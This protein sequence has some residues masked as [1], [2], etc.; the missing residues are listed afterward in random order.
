MESSEELSSG[1]FLGKILHK[2]VENSLRKGRCNNNSKCLTGYKDLFVSAI[3]SSELGINADPSYFTSLAFV[4]KLIIREQDVAAKKGY[5]LC[6][7]LTS[8]NLDLENEEPV[9]DENQKSERVL[10]VPQVVVISLRSIFDLI[11]E[12]QVTHP[13]LCFKVLKALL[14]ILQNLFPESL[15]SEPCHVVEPLFEL[16][17]KLSTM[18]DAENTSTIETQEVGESLSSLASSCLLSLVI[19]WGVTPRILQALDALITVARPLA[20]QIIVLPNIMLTLQKGVRSTVIGTSHVP[21]WFTQG[22]QQKTLVTCFSVNL[23]KDLIENSI[24]CDGPFIF[25]L[26]SCGLYKIGSGL[27]STVS[28]RLYASNKKNVPKKGT[29]L[30]FNGQLFLHTYSKEDRNLHIVDN[31]TLALKDCINL[32]DSIGKNS[33]LFSDGNRLGSVFKTDE[34]ELHATLFEINK[35]ELFS[36]GES[37]LRLALQSLYIVGASI[38][39]EN[40]DLRQIN[41]N[42]DEGFTSIVAGKEFMLMVSSSGKVSYQGKASSLGLKTVGELVHNQEQT[43]NRW[44]ELPLPKSPSIVRC[45]TGHDGLH[46]V[47]LG[48][49]GTA[50]FAGLAKRGEDGDLTKHRRQQ[51]SSRPKRFSSIEGKVVVD[52]ACNNGSSAMVTKD[53]EL[54]LFGKDSTYCESTSGRLLGIKDRIV[55]VALG[56]AHGVTLTDKGVVY[57]FGINNKGQCGRDLFSS[58]QAKQ[59]ENNS[60]LQ[61]TTLLSACKEPIDDEIESEDSGS[62]TEMK[63]CAAD[64][65]H[66]SVD[67]CM[68][69]TQCGQCTGFGSTC[70]NTNSPGRIPGT[71]CGCGSGEAGCTVCGACR[72]CARIPN[73]DVG[74]GLPPAPVPIISLGR[75]RGS[76]MAANNAVLMGRFVR[77]PAEVFP[78]AALVDVANFRASRLDGRGIDDPK[79]REV[80]LGAALNADVALDGNRRHR[81]HRR[82][83][84]SEVKVAMMN[85]EAPKGWDAK[86][87]PAGQP[88]KNGIDAALGS[89]GDRDTNKLASLSPGPIS[90]HSKVRVSQVACGLHHSVLLTTDGQVY[91]FGSNSYGQLGV[92]DLSS[93]GSP[94]LVKMPCAVNISMIAAGSHHTVVLTTDGDVLTWGAH[95]KGQLARDPSNID[96]CGA[97]SIVWHSVP[98]FVTHIGPKCGKRASWIGASGDQ[99]FFKLEE[100]LVSEEEFHHSTVLATD[101]YFAILPTHSKPSSRNLVI[102]RNDGQCRSFSG[103][104]QANFANTILTWDPVYSILWSFCKS[105]SMVRGYNVFASGLVH[106]SYGSSLLS[107]MKEQESVD[108]AD[109]FRP[110]LTLP[111]VPSSKVTQTQAALHLLCCLDSLTRCQQIPIKEITN[112]DPHKSLV[113][114]CFTKEDFSV[115]NR[116]ESHGGGWGYSGHSVEAIRFM[117]DTD[118]LLGGFSL[119]GGRGEYMGKIKVFDLGIGGGDQEG[120]GE[121]LAETDEVVYECGAR[122]RF[123]ILFSQPLRL[124][125]NRWYLAWARVNGPSSDCGSGGQSTVTTEDQVTFTFKPSKKSNNG[126]DVNAGQLPQILFRV[127]AHDAPSSKPHSSIET[128]HSISSNFSKVVTPDSFTALLNLTQWAW[129]ALKAMTTNGLTGPEVNLKE[130]HAHIQDLSRIV[131]VCRVSMRLLRFYILELYPVKS[132][133]PKKLIEESVAVVRAIVNVRTTLRSILSDPVLGLLNK[134]HTVGLPCNSTYMVMLEQVAKETHD[135]FVACFHVFYPTASLKWTILCELLD[136]IQK[137]SNAPGNSDQLLAAVIDSLCSHHIRLRSAVPNLCDLQE[138]LHVRRQFQSPEMEGAPCLSSP[139]ENGSTSPTLPQ[140]DSHQFPVLVEHMVEGQS[141]VHRPC[142]A[143]LDRLFLIATWPVRQSLDMEPVI[144]SDKLVQYSCRLLA[145]VVAELASQ[146]C[147]IEELDVSTTRGILATPSRF[148]SSSQNRSWNTGNG[149]PDA[150]CFTVDRPNVSVIGVGVFGG[151]GSYTYELELLELIRSASDAAQTLSWHSLAVVRGSYGPEDSIN[152]VAEIKF[153]RPVPIKENTRYTFRLRN[154]GGKTHNGDGGVLSIKGPD[155]TTFNFSACLLSFNGTNHIRGQLPYILYCNIPSNSEVQQSSLSAIGNQARKSIMSITSSI[156]RCTS[157]LLCAARSLPIHHSLPIIC[158]SHVVSYLL[159]FVVANIGVV[160]ESDPKNAVQILELIRVLLPHVS[161]LCLADILSSEKGGNMPD[162]DPC[163]TTSPKV[164]VVE[165]DHPYRPATV[166]HFRVSFPESVRW[167]CLEFDGQ[168]CTSQVE[169]SLQL[170]LPSVFPKNQADASLADYW[171]ALKKFGG[172]DNWPTHSMIL[173]GNEVIFS[174]ESASDCIR[175]DKAS[176]WGFRCTVVGYEWQE[177]NN[178]I[179]LLETELAYLGGMCSATLMKRDLALPQSRGDEMDADSMESITQQIY[180]A[181]TGLLSKG[182]A[183]SQLPTIHEA[184]EGNLPFSVS[185][186]ERQF[187]RDFVSASEETSGGRLARWLQPESVVDPSKSQLIFPG[188]FSASLATFGVPNS[189]SLGTIGFGSPIKSVTND[190]D[191]EDEETPSE[192]TTVTSTTTTVVSEGLRAGW[193]AILTLLTRDQYGHLVH[194]PNLKVNIR[195]VPCDLTQTTNDALLSPTKRLYSGDEKNC[196]EHLEPVLDVPY[197]VT[198]KD[199]MC[200]HAITFLKAYENYSFEELRFVSPIKRR[201]SETMLVRPNADGSYSANWTPSAAGLYSIHVTIDGYPL[202]EV[203]KVDVKEPPQGVLPPSH[204]VTVRN[205]SSPSHRLRQFRTRASAGLRVRAQPS[206]QGEQI[207]IVACEGTISF[208]EELCNDDGTWLR[209]STESIREWCINPYSEAWCLQYNQHISKTLLFPIST[210]QNEGDEMGDDPPSHHKNSQ[211]DSDKKEEKVFSSAQTF[212]VVDCGASGHNIRALPSLKALPVG[213]LKLGSSFLV[214]EQR[215]TSEGAWVKLLPSS[216]RQ[217]CSNNELEAWSLAVDRHQMVYLRHEDEVLSVSAGSDKSSPAQLLKP[218]YD[219]SESAERQANLSAFSSPEPVSTFI[220]GIDKDSEFPRPTSSQKSPPKGEID[221]S[222]KSNV[223]STSESTASLHVQEASLESSVEDAGALVGSCGP[224]AAVA[225]GRL[226]A[227]QNWLRRDGSLVKE[228]PSPPPRSRNF[229]PELQGVSVKDMVRVMGESRANGN[230]SPSSSPIPSRKTGAI[231]VVNRS[232]SAHSSPGGCS[233][234][235]GSL[236]SSGTVKLE[237]TQ[238][239]RSLSPATQM[240]QSVDQSVITVMAKNVTQMGTQ[241]S[242]EANKTNQ[243]NLGAELISDLTRSPQR[244]SPKASRTKERASRGGTRSRKSR[245][246]TAGQH[247]GGRSLMLEQEIA[248]VGMSPSTAECLRAVF[249]AN[250]WH[251]GLVH[252]AMACAS[253]LK[254][255]PNLPKQVDPIVPLRGDPRHRKTREE[256]ARQRHSVEIFSTNMLSGPFA[257]P[258]PVALEESW[259]TERGE[260]ASNHQIQPDVPDNKVASSLTPTLS[261]LVELWEKMSG[262]CV[263]LIQSEPT[264]SSSTLSV[265]QFQNESVSK[266]KPK[267]ENRDARDKERKRKSRRESIRPESNC[268]LCGGLF[269]VPVTA[270]MRQAHPGC[271]KPAL[272]LGYNPDGQYCGGW[273]GNCGEGGIQGSSWYLLCEDCRHRYLQQRRQVGEA[274]GLKDD[275]G[276]RLRRK[277]SITST[278]TP[279]TQL[280]RPSTPLETHVILKDNALFLLQLA[281]SSSPEKNQQILE[282]RRRSLMHQPSLSSVSEIDKDLSN[283]KISAPPSKSGY[284]ASGDIFPWLQFQ[285]LPVLKSGCSP[286]LSNNE[287]NFGDGEVENS[288]EMDPCRGIKESCDGFGRQLHRSVSMIT[289]PLAQHLRSSQEPD[290]SITGV[291]QRRRTSSADEQGIDG[292]LALLRSPSKALQDT[293]KLMSGS[294]DHAATQSTLPVLDFVAQR[295]DLDSLR[296]SMELALRKASCRVFA[297]ENLSWLLQNVTQPVC[298]H[299]LLWWLVSSLAPSLETANNKVETGGADGST[300]KDNLVGQHP[301][302]DVSLAGEG[303]SPLLQSFHGLLQTVSNL[304]Q[305][306]PMGTPLLAMAVR[307]W[308][309]RFKQTDHAF[310]HKSH[311]FSNISRILSRCEEEAT[312]DIEALENTAIHS[313]GH[314]TMLTEV[315]EGIDIKVSSRTA[316]VN[317][318]TDGSTETFWE[319]GDEDRGKMKLITIQVCPETAGFPPRIVCLYVDNSRDMGNKVSGVTFKAGPNGEELQIVDVL[320]V[321][322][323]FSGWL[324]TSLPQIN[325]Q[326]IQLELKG[327]DNSLRIRQVRLLGGGISRSFNALAIHQRTCETET[328]RVFR[329]LTSQV[330]GRL[331]LNEGDA[332]PSRSTD[333]G[334]NEDEMDGEIA[335]RT[336][337]I[338]LK[339]HMVGI[340]FSGK[341]LTHLQRQVCTHILHGIQRE[342]VRLKEEWDALLQLEQQNDTLTGTDA[343]NHDAGY[344]N[345]RISD[346]YCFELL[347]QVLA[348][349]GS[350]VGRTYISQQSTLP[351]NLLSLLHTGSP[352]IQRQVTALL[353]RMLPEL[354]PPVFASLVGVDV[355]PTTDYGILQVLNSTGSIE[356]VGI[357]D[358]FLACIAKALTIQVKSKGRDKESS[359][360]PIS[361]VTMASIFNNRQQPQRQLGSRWW[362]RGHMPRRV[363]ESIIQLVRDMASGNLSEVWSAVTKAGIAEAV[364]ALTKLDEDRRSSLDCLQTPSVWLTLAALCLLQDEHVERLSSTQWARGAVNKPQCNNHD[365]GETGAQ[366]VCSDCGP[367][368]IDCDRVL[369]LSR[370]FRSH[371]RQVCKEE[372]EAIKVDVHEG[373]GRVKLFWILALSDARNL[374][375]LVE[376]RHGVTTAVSSVYVTAATNESGNYH[377]SLIGGVGASSSCRY[378][379][380]AISPSSASL[381]DDQTINVCSEPDCVE[382]SR[383]ACL[384]TLGCGHP[385]GGVRGES[386]CLPCLFRCSGSS[387]NLKQDADDMCMICF[388]EALSAAPAIQLSCKHVFHAHCCRSVLS[389]KWPGPRITFSFSRC[390]ICK[391]ELR[392]EFLDDLL[393]PIRELFEDVKRKAL[394][395]LEYEGLHQTEAIS[396]PGNRFFQDAEGYAMERYAYYVCFRCNKAYYG[397]EARCEEGLAVEGVGGGGDSFNPSELVCGGCSDVSRAQMCPRHGA[398]YLEYKCRYCCSVA[399]FFCFGTTH[400]CNACHEDFRHVTE[401]PKHA[402]PKCPAGPRGR[403]LDGDE[404]PLHL[405]HPPTGEEFALG[406]GMCRNAHT[407]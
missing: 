315:T 249:A 257:S 182:L 399:V 223:Q 184:L 321:E 310:L 111:V 299:D 312:V 313:A 217:F 384:K 114:R 10:Q 58:S 157:D 62:A 401:M 221:Q 324:H 392:N 18:T 262:R 79:M 180:T 2:V 25:L 376:F 151:G 373:C 358:V 297:M 279:T 56:K 333:R 1:S 6:K 288:F 251:Q 64:E 323:R 65:H 244:L 76:P 259:N 240:S 225:V 63:L 179:R 201:T 265:A 54:F 239:S 100:S 198:T 261:L 171:P 290:G 407:F 222:P 84:P 145:R 228:A 343:I 189:T 127:I 174:L 247:I 371:Q 254:F 155:G 75:G 67:Q 139:S 19:A 282:R 192:A 278:T 92:G 83:H 158:K 15:M 120:D 395:R 170:Y 121:L 46:A 160:A 200:L 232:L 32:Q 403:Q 17:L 124:Q 162:E 193:P 405:V 348:L 35:G 207:G 271:Q 74:I 400:F 186:K 166:S 213:K 126:T 210:T 294:H 385:C 57:T 108:V 159:P 190:K 71:F 4:R 72:T 47:F 138:S 295:H 176:S 134:S 287:V 360:N 364:L 374:K 143:V 61:S 167:M 326:I 148:T 197:D 49:D 286:Q 235:S 214:T 308:D 219:F 21:D 147:S 209:L 252:D 118:I 234:P 391:A 298:L 389:K 39:D 309:I 329:L 335:E 353:R 255:H 341:K 113:N 337:D 183:L 220:F 88:Q 23:G 146:V 368:C 378:C 12:S 107:V 215:Q 246:P 156:V 369:H 123:P 272:G 14:G 152:D 81:H 406:C 380:S 172:T 292:G 5:N 181:H 104:E 98:G 273:V 73:S 387:A 69:C 248:R 281:T 141:L 211:A 29:L 119:F 150:I 346:S 7:L 195:A 44:Y 50:F 202:D 331:I 203:Y 393:I 85:R 86:K 185:G 140:M 289:Q 379:S 350:R 305:L 55:K 339:E 275:K 366:I 390:P 194:V 388:T 351:A 13:Q 231:A 349:S 276:K 161:A 99:T 42:A 34:D 365:D 11:Q 188:V 122:Q 187:L 243:F 66:W 264:A 131:F 112:Q 45:A 301:T 154:Q 397:G 354:P 381:F 238:R 404:C 40:T 133:N 68:V 87:I 136:Q 28:G 38:N 129:S 78:N 274:F 250:L 168:C 52:I 375:S 242:P 70:V 33:S 109:I 318:L 144:W 322:T 36:F 163:I 101:H 355:L 370:K 230:A 345:S 260:S 367:L 212:Y 116:F 332:S 256:K 110:A 383:N 30:F 304:M 398:D 338:D 175:I 91:T 103:T 164:V 89:D 314:V 137:V 153:D 306:L 334:P 178:A 3:T 347:S 296:T 362:M 340:L 97:S 102:N 218:A 191:E 233:K 80:L 269:A 205:N 336:R 382:Y 9:T 130:D 227:F 320:E 204:N 37:R 128:V 267:T 327:P 177:T 117:S 199:R 396:L 268:E 142:R 359:K 16:L 284:Q 291:S 303:L 93:R 43:S 330:F 96:H 402:L 106:P 316:M 241:T 125:A 237:N 135:S 22:I 27:G 165:S 300:S 325:F 53:G 270:H 253:F 344:V 317:S 226:S 357:L 302:S 285:C 386:E 319:S 20:A 41:F 149:S 31:E 8:S 169:D 77:A 356:R 48:A 90:F 51:K 263:E 377:G 311:V 105:T 352:R 59:S 173:P 394:M 95:L 258:L 293:V 94:N 307:C 361:S 280:L 283:R 328:L 363:A 60:Q 132:K 24:A 196:D 208:I 277:V 229:P 26:S 206:L 236:P 224:F 342:T 82:R 245:S 115:V 372:E 216:A 266:A